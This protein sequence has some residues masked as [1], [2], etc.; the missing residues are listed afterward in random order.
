MRIR[1]LNWDVL[2][3]GHSVRLRSAL[4]VSFVALALSMSSPRLV[5]AKHGTQ[6]PA[7]TPRESCYVTASA[8]TVP[9]VL[10]T[11][12][13]DC[14]VPPQPDDVSNSVIVR[15]TISTRGKVIRAVAES[16]PDRYRVAATR[17]ARKWLF[18]PTEL[19]TGPKR[20]ITRISFEYWVL[21]P[22]AAQLAHAAERAQ[23]E[24]VLHP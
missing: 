8:P 11:V 24:F 19:A 12:L 5:V 20:A 17:A 18:K 21:P 16:G 15:I 14:S 13:P 9:Q 1:M 2:A 6:S 23:R 22:R 10:K 7:S 3:T 4:L